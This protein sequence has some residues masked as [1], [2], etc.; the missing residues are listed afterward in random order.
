MGLFTRDGFERFVL[1]LPAA[2]IVHQ[3]RDASVGKVGGKVFALFGGNQ[4][5]PGISFKCS[6]MA[7][8]LLPELNGIAPAPY[9]ARAKWVALGP[10]S[11]L[12]EAELGA[13]L[14]EAHALIAKRLTRAQ[15]A[16]LGL[17]AYLLTR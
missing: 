15:R 14:T 4:D 1:A 12:S 2:E 8:E 10:G 7:F 9:F 6:D 11:A 17:D 16:A 3:W 13:Y 5:R